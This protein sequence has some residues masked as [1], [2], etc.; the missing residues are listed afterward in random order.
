MQE[1]GTLSS[2]LELCGFEYFVFFV[3]SKVFIE[4]LCGN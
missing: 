3:C 2:G 4:L 1:L